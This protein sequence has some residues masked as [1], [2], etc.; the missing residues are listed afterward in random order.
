MAFLY[1]AQKRLEDI[2]EE[3][4]ED[5]ELLPAEKFGLD[6]RCGNLYMGEDFIA[7][8]IPRDRTLQ[9]YGGFEYVDTDCRMVIGDYVFYS[10]DA[11]RVQDAM[12]EAL[13][14]LNEGEEEEAFSDNGEEEERMVLG[15][16]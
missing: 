3:L 2:A 8:N 1:T 13:G 15:N 9:Y 7:V 14:E 4:I 11:D 5:A 10:S 6:E 16:L 12:D